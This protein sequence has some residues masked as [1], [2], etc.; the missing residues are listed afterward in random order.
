[1]FFRT[2]KSKGNEYLQIVENRREG[3]KTKQTV[4]A[5]LGRLDELKEAGHLEALLRSGA[6]FSEKLM[7]LEAHKR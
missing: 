2:K 1:M 3:R 6:R 5:T 7:I 4:V